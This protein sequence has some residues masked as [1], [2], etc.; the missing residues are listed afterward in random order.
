MAHMIP[1]YSNEPFVTMTGEDGED[2]ALPRAEARAFPGTITV[3]EPGWFC[4]LSAPGYLDCTDWD[5]PFET[6]EE[7]KEHITNTFM[8]NAETGAGLEV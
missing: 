7:A 4:R 2:F 3:C 1:Q 5:G 6:L 8:V